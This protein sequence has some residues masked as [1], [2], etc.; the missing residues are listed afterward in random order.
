[1][2]ARKDLSGAGV[3]FEAAA[4]ALA[5]GAPAGALTAAELRIAVL[6]AHPA[7]DASEFFDAA[8]AGAASASLR[9]VAEAWGG[10]AGRRLRYTAVSRGAPLPPFGDMLQRSGKDADEA[11]GAQIEK[12][13]WV[14]AVLSLQLEEAV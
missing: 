7:L 3:L 11:E 4:Q 6:E 9:A 13:A 12:A 5:A 10:P 8:A 2:R 1:M 14:R